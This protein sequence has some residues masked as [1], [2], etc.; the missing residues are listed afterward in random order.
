MSL[1]GCSHGY[2]S[3]VELAKLFCPLP[4]KVGFVITVVPLFTDTLVWR[5]SKGCGTGLIT[6]LCSDLWV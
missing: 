1:P 2:V 6:C 5:S 4:V 3:G